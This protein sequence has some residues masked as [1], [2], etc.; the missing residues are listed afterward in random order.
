M[1]EKKKKKRNVNSQ[2]QAQFQPNP[3]G[4]L[5]FIW[6]NFSEFFKEWVEIS[7]FLCSVLL[8]DKNN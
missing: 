4:H 1:R 6:T 3:N 8:V 2:T 5:V 7:H